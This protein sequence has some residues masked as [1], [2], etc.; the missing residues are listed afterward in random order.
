MWNSENIYFCGMAVELFDANAMAVSKDNYRI[1]R[2]D[3]QLFDLFST[4]QLVD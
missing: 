1:I 4:R 2:S 3:F